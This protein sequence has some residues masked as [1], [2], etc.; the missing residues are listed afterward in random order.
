MYEAFTLA[1]LYELDRKLM[2]A[3]LQA[4][5]V[6]TD[7]TS[8]QPNPFVTE[9]ETIGTEVWDALIDLNQAQDQEV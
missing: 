9:L 4:E 1:E 3:Y 5:S 7:A 2:R 6:W 8:N